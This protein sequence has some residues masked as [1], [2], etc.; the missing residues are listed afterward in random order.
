MRIPI[1][2]MRTA[3][4]IAKGIV[5]LSSDDAG[6]TTDAGLVVDGSIPAE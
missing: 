5:S 2:R 4:D 6:F 3:T 1:G